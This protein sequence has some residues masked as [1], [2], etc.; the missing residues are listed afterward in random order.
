M[1]TSLEHLSATKRGQLKVI[2][3]IIAKAIRPEKIILFGTHG[4]ID[5]GTEMWT[6]KQLMHCMS[7]FDLLIVTRRG[8]RRYDHEIQ[9][10]IENRCRTHTPVT[11]LIHDID[12]VNKRLVG[13]HYFFSMMSRE[14]IL[15][16][17]AG[18]VPLALASLPDLPKIKE[19]AQ[20][21]FENWRGSAN[22]YFKS[23][24]FNLYEKEFKVAIF[25]LHQAAE[26]IYQAILLT[27]TGYK[28][29]THNLDKLR[30]YTNRF[31]IE[32][33]MLFPRNTK[34]EDD[35]F[36]LLLQ[37]YVDARYCDE[38]QITEEEVTLLIE[39]IARL[40]SIADRVCKNRFVSLD[41]MASDASAA[42]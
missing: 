37:G 26:R 17:D 20:K 8:E 2:T 41:K 14:A 12:Y 19:T 27:F 7:S 32:L 11:V 40:M 6:D 38:Y 36:K 23:A 16:Y 13:G 24:V 3:R 25:L 22:A 31:S 35:L 28:P 18:N 10:I 15:L 29:C 30:R 9:D 1:N 39:R 21:D 33:A 42:I 34:E 5:G 4:S